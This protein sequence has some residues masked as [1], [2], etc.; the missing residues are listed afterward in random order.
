MDEDVAG[1]MTLRSH[2][3]HRLPS[4]G[5]LTAPLPGRSL[6]ASEL[7]TRQAGAEEA[8][9]ELPPRLVL[10]LPQVPLRDLRVYEEVADGVRA[11]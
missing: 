11:G 8:G 1:S 4:L 2:D 7:T 3:R 6:P 9:A 5:A 10:D